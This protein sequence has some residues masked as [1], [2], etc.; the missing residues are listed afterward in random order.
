MYRIAA[1]IHLG[2]DLRIPAETPWP[3]E[4]R[5]LDISV[6]AREDLM[7]VMPRRQLPEQ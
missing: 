3:P 5:L 4:V 2:A 7:I 1:A 6:A